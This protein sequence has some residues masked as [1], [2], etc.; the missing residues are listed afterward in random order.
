[1]VPDTQL[2][3]L[4]FRNQPVRI[5]QEPDD[6]FIP[7]VDVATAVAMSKRSCLRVLDRN[8]GL[9]SAYERGIHLDTPGGRQYTRCLNR[10]GTLGL[11]F[12]VSTNHVKDD[13]IKDRLI[14]FQKWA[15]DVLGK[16]STVRPPMPMPAL[17]T[18]G[19]PD[20]S[21]KVLKYLEFADLFA[22]QTGADLPRARVL[23]LDAACKEIGVD[24]HSFKSIIP[25]IATQEA[26]YLTPTQIAERISKPGNRQFSGHEVNTF[27]YNRGYQEKDD[28][29]AWHP[30]EKGKV[31]SKEIPW[32]RGSASGMQVLWREEIIQLEK[33]V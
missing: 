3:I 2:S 15:I 27:L 31:F 18:S 5:I 19:E 16:N 21:Q 29:G 33:M 22:A 12:K 28:K 13:K 11:L 9:F 10:Y 24:L 20:W 14:E 1:M 6:T 25:G 32:M 4:S 8:G 7:V 23:A 17:L 26:G 30:T